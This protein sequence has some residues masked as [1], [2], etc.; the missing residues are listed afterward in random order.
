MCVPTASNLCLADKRIMSIHWACNSKSVVL[1]VLMHRAA[2]VHTYIN[3]LSRI[4][5]HHSFVSKTYTLRRGH[6]RASIAHFPSRHIYEQIDLSLCIH[7]NANE[8]RVR[9]SVCVCG[10]L[11]GERHY[12]EMKEKPLNFHEINT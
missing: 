10:S 3:V 7:T 2:G 9:M 5:A 11:F 4:D 8:L 6:T 12:C 1:L